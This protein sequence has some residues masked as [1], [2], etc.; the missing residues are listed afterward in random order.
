MK[1]KFRSKPK[2]EITDDSFLHQSEFYKDGFYEGYLIQDRNSAYLVN[3]VTEC[4]EEFIAIE[5][6]CVIDAKTIEPLFPTCTANERKHLDREG[7]KLLTQGL[8]YIEEAKEKHYK[9]T[10]NSLVDDW[11]Q[12]VKK[13]VN[14]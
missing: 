5:E 8:S 9:N 11:I 4:Q 1:F 14:E 10:N 6:W 2:N 7:I 13:L 3:G 12:K